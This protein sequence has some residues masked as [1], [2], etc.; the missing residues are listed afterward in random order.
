MHVRLRNYAVS[1]VIMAVLEDGYTVR[2]VLGQKYFCLES[3]LV[4]MI[5]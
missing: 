2:D 3:E 4:A 1:G 5:Q